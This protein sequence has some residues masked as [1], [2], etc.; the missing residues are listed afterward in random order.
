MTV[1]PKI[2]SYQIN[3]ATVLCH[4]TVTSSN[5]AFPKDRQLIILALY[6][7]DHAQTHPAPQE[8]CFNRGYD[9]AL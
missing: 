8:L 1:I 2:F 4:V 6:M 9:N 7:I 5:E 3:A